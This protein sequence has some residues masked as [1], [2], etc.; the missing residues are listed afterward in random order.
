[1]TDTAPTEKNITPTEK[2]TSTTIDSVLNLSEARKITGFSA[3]K[4]STEKN[5]AALTEKG[6]DLSA[7]EPKNFKIPVKALVELDWLNE[8]LSPKPAR[9]RKPRTTGS[10][11]KAATGDK[12][13]SSEGQLKAIIEQADEEIDSL[14][15]QIT[16]INGQIKDAKGRRR[17]ATRKIDGARSKDLKRLQKEAED[18]RIQADT[19]Q[20]A[21]AEREAELE[22]L[23]AE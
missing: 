22:R 4:F 11:S 5:I 3:T 14:T 10:T 15:E 19:A 12:G 16:E 1:M 17:E 20:K 8:D 7:K 9:P 13:I 18:L 6:A 23:L 2:D 21:A